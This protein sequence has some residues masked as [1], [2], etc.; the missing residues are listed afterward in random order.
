MTL[1]S[2]FLPIPF[3]F[4]LKIPIFNPRTSNEE[5]NELQNQR[6]NQD[7]TQDQ[8]RF[9]LAIQ[10]L[11]DITDPEIRGKVYKQIFGECCDEQMLAMIQNTPQ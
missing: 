8:T 6:Y 3:P 5:S 11:N 4:Q 7:M 1:H 9:E 10:T 2:A